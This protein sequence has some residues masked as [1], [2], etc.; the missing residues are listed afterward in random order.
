MEKDRELKEKGRELREK[1]KELAK[2]HAAKDT[3][4]RDKNEELAKAHAAKDTVVREKD[5]AVKVA[6]QH[7]I[8]IVARNKDYDTLEQRLKVQVEDTR[9]ARAETARWRLNFRAGNSVTAGPIGRPVGISVPW[10]QD[11]VVEKAHPE[12]DPAYVLAPDVQKQLESGY[13]E[14]VADILKMWLGAPDI[15]VFLTSN[16]R[17]LGDQTPDI[18]LCDKRGMQAHPLAVYGIIEIKAPGVSVTALEPLGKVRDY[19]LSIAS[20]QPGRM[21]F[22]GYLTNL[23]DNVLIELRRLFGTMH[24]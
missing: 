8:S 24:Q 21:N 14:L 2:A 22:W 20:A 3:A 10:N 6:H 11:T 9:R 5:M 17:F 16:T 4:I 7:E 13:Y 23:R 1:D 12:L 18:S 15:E 19:L